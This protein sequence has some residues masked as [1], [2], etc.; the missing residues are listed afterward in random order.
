LQHALTELMLGGANQLHYGEGEQGEGEEGGAG[1]LVAGLR[2]ELA[3]E[4]DGEIANQL[5]IDGEIEMLPGLAEALRSAIAGRG[6][7][8]PHVAVRFF[9]MGGEEADV[10]E[11]LRRAVGGEEGGRMRGG[12]EA[13]GKGERAEGED[14][15]ED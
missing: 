10:G 14:G 13:A 1:D 3:G 5:E 6:Q 4:I 12:R 2:A 11:M 9:A 7:A 15:E 8:A